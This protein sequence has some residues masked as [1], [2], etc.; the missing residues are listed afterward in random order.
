M[1]PTCQGGRVAEGAHLGVGEAGEQR[2]EA[3]KEEAIVEDGVAAP[4]GHR[5]HHRPKRGP[6]TAPRPR[7]EGQGVV[8]GVLG[9]GHGGRTGTRRDEAAG[10]DRREMGAEREK[11]GA[12]REKMRGT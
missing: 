3:A 4:Q 11:M 1:S 10:M 6:K 12:E 5:R 9:G 8:G 2:G 7:G